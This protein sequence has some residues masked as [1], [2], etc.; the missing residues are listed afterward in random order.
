MPVH[1]NRGAPAP[2]GFGCLEPSKE[3]IPPMPRTRQQNVTAAQWSANGN[4]LGSPDLTVAGNQVFAANVFSP[5]VQRQRLPKPIFKALK[6]PS[7]GA[8][9]WTPPSPTRWPTP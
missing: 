6:R 8:S 7:S 1:P 4:G 2:P 5:A 3:S 9:R